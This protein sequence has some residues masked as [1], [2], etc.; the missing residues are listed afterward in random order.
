MKYRDGLAMV[1]ALLAFAAPLEGQEGNVT[2]G[3]FVTT[4]LANVMQLEEGMREH[5][6]WHEQQ[7]DTWPGFVYQAMHGGNEYVWVSPGH[8]WADFDDPTVDPQADMQ[9]FAQAAG[10]H[11]TGLDVRTWVTWDDVSMPPAQD[12]VV[13]IWE[14][15]EW[16]VKA[17]SEGLEALRSAFGK[18]RA[19]FEQE[20]M[21]LRYTVNQLVGIDSAPQMFV[22]I[23]HDSMGEMDGAEPGAL[24]RLLVQA[25]GHADAVHT[26]RS[27][28]AYLTPTASRVWVLRP[29][30]SHLPGM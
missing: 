7:N 21:A 17:T 19:A 12:A 23:A 15:V 3:Y 4:D 11:T 20:G 27:F 1:C 14:V 24:E 6:D 16:D 25:H 13:P 28:E 9:D 5:V 18:V 8:T 10:S 26:I 29:D 22:A 30:L 2:M